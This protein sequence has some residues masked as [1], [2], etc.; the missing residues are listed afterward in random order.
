MWYHFAILLLPF[1]AGQVNLRDV[2]L[3]TFRKGLSTT[4]KRTSPVAQLVCSGSACGT[5]DEPA[6]VYCENVGR[7][8]REV[9][10]WKCTADLDSNVILGDVDVNCEGY[11]SSHDDL[12]LSGSCGLRYSLK[13]RN[14]H[15][16][17]QRAGTSNF[18]SASYHSASE[19]YG[20]RAN[21]SG[22]GGGLLSFIVFLAAVAG[23]VLFMASRNG[24][25]HQ[26]SGYRR[27][28]DFPSGGRPGY[29]PDSGPGYPGP[30]YGGGSPGYGGG[31]PGYGPSCGGSAPTAGW[32][33]GFWSGMA[34]GGLLG[35]MMG[36]RPS[37][38][39]GVGRF[40]SGYGSGAGMGFGSP[41]NSGFSSGFSSGRSPASSGGTRTATAF[42]GTSMR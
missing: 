9:V 3:L 28:G 38:S 1:C 18:H 33:P 13:Y 8:D 4:G 17:Q 10:S 23:I 15:G 37:Y 22:G 5:D 29:P 34:G 27:T 40:G 19:D 21:T 24:P 25:P 36:N 6:V 35:Y 42:G 14:G 12:V 32:T 41:V 30:G 39:S 16:K 2:N 26:T 20:R 7:D 31:G 11:R